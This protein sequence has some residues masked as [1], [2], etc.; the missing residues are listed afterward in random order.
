MRNKIIKFILFFIPS[1]V[2]LAYYAKKNLTKLLDSDIFEFDFSE[3]E[4]EEI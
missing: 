1:V 3:D 2:L 4:E